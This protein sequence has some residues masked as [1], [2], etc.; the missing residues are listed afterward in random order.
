MG[1]CCRRGCRRDSCS[2]RRSQRSDLLGRVDP[3]SHRPMGRYPRRRRA[4]LHGLRQ[5]LLDRT[6]Q[7]LGI[8]PRLC[9][10]ADPRR[11]SR[12]AH[13]RG[14]WR[15]GPAARRRRRD[16][17]DDPCLGLQRRRLPRADVHDGHAAAARIGGAEAALPARHRIRRNADAGLRGDRTDHRIGHDPAENPRGTRGKSICG[18]WPEGLDFPRP[19]IGPDAALGSHDAG[20]PGATPLGW[21]FGLPVGSARSGRQW[22][23]DQEARRGDQSQH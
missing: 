2:P 16:P 18:Q 5:R 21:H 22:D 17:R 15:R 13:P 4:D 20:R 12:R 23:R 1:M 3:S 6:R 8:P 11:L 7:G 14:I 10:R 9:G 19:A